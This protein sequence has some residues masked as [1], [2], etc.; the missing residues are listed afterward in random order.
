MTPAATASAIRWPEHDELFI[1]KSLAP[2]GATMGGQIAYP[3]KPLPPFQTGASG[4]LIYTVLPALSYATVPH[5]FAAAI[6]PIVCFANLPAAEVEAPLIDPLPRTRKVLRLGT[7]PLRQ[8]APRR[9][10]ISALFLTVDE[11]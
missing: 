11:E 7:K 4:P 6:T 10:N 3:V 8:L 1:Q 2:S 9:P 5:G